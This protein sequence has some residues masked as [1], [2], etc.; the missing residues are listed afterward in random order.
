MCVIDAIDKY[1]GLFVVKNMRNP[2][3]ILLDRKTH[4]DLCE[5][6]SRMDKQEVKSLRSFTLLGVRLQVFVVYDKDVVILP[7]IL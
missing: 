4:S 3:A 1:V 7:C 5:A 2:N 6:L